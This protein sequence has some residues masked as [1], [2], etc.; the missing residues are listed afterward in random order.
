MLVSFR[1]SDIMRVISCISPPSVPAKFQVR[2]QLQVMHVT[3]I[4]SDLCDNT[5]H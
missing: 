3:Q 4:L 5:K 1:I 2:L